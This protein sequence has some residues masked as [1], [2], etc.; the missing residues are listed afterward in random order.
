[1]PFFAQGSPHSAWTAHVPSEAAFRG[2]GRLGFDSGL[3]AF[4]VSHSSY[5]C[6]SLSGPSVRL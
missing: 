4:R 1:M 2:L 5:V 6:V 3:E